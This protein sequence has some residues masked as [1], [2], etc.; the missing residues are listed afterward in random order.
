MKQ[1]VFQKIK[2][3]FTSSSSKSTYKQS[4]PLWYIDNL[5]RDESEYILSDKEN[6]VFLIRK[7]ESMS[8]CLVLSVKVPIAKFLITLLSKA[9]KASTFEDS[10]INNSK[11]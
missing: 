4:L 3:R 1:S 8:D 10:I 5:T 2:A 6:D 7:S 9:K 11:I